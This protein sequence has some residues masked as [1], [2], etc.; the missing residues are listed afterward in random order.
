MSIPCAH[1]WLINV[2]FDCKELGLFREMADSR[3]G[4]HMMSLEHL[5]LHSD[6]DTSTGHRAN[7]R[8][9]SHPS[10]TIWAS[11]SL[12][13]GRDYNPLNKTGKSSTY[14][15]KEIQG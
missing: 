11:W 3:L 14:M 5:V 8:G 10:G 7:V 4:E 1:F 6:G 12:T 13:I 9:F 15:W 2:I